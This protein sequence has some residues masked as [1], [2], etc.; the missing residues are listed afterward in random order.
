VKALVLIGMPGAGKSTVGVL[1]AKTLKR[2]FIDTDLL[3]Q[4]RENRFLREIIAQEG[5]EALLDIEARVIDELTLQG[6]VIATGGS[7][8][9]REAAMAHLHA[10]GVIVYLSLPYAV[11]ER[12]IRNITNRGIAIK[13]GQS[14]R[15]LYDE[16]QPST[17]AMPTSP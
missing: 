1:L 9:Y 5:M 11:I 2:P 17:H 4:Q 7:V 3:I 16:R 13:P 10:N 15:N 12:R 6:Q 14:L 8:I